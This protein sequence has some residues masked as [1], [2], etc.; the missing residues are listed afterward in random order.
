MHSSSGKIKNFHEIHL[1]GILRPTLS[2]TDA[3]QQTVAGKGAG[4]KV[5]EGFTRFFEAHH[6]FVHSQV[7]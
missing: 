7:N 1:V 3:E 5:L 4:F 6:L 2:P